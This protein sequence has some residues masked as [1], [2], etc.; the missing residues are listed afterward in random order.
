MRAPAIR[1]PT[2]APAMSPG[3]IDE[4][5]GLVVVVAAAVVVK[6]EKEKDKEVMVVNEEEKAAVVL[7]ALVLA[8]DFEV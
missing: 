4:P 5:D 7:E 6:E 1:L 3:V 2:A 8:S